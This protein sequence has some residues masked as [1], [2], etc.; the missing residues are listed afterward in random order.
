[1]VALV[2]F[3]NRNDFRPGA[4][5]DNIEWKKPKALDHEDKRPSSTTSFALQSITSN[6]QTSAIPA[7]WLPQ[8][9]FTKSVEIEQVV[10]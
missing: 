10:L 3:L 8:Q 5:D 4:I 7:E 9:T 6:N 1:M 2:T